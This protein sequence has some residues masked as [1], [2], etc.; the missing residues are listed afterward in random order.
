M[1]GFPSYRAASDHVLHTYK[2]CETRLDLVECRRIEDW[3]SRQIESPAW[4]GDLTEAR[5]RSL[6]DLRA[7]MAVSF[8]YQQ[9]RVA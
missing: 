7:A 1:T 2:G 8:S 9:E 3:L 6:A 4:S 5:K